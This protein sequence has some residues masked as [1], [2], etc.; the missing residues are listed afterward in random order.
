[1]QVNIECEA[2]GAD[3]EYKPGTT[4][5]SCDYCQHTMEF[6]DADAPQDIQELDLETYLNN[7]KEENDHLDLHVVSCLSCGAETALEENQQSGSCPFCDAALVITQAHSKR[8]IKPKSLLPFYI[9]KVEAKSQFRKWLTGL[10]FAPGDLKKFVSQHDKF[11]GIYLPY[12]TYDCST[13]NSYT[14]KRGDYY[15]ETETRTNA[16]GETV[17]E[18]V[19][20]TRWRTV[21]DHI[22]VD[23]DDILIPATNSLPLDKLYKLEPWDLEDLVDFKDE[24][25]S[26][27]KTESYQVELGQGY[28]EAKEIMEER[29]EQFVTEDIGGDRQ[30]II[31]I[32]TSYSQ[33]T[34]KH[35]LLPVWVSAYHYKGKLYQILVNARTGEVQG[36][37]PYSWKKIVLTIVCSLALLTGAVQLLR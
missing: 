10:W 35:L 13:S 28:D 9:E 37:R 22:Y 33:A 34:F 14:G 32:N 8:L 36:E 12:W 16:K 4:G 5:L 31:S 27:Y 15:Y 11:H 1:M 19:R 20:K 3:L 17:S 26:G 6:H 23:F 24:Y 7:F 29:I 18:K 30:R 21:S 2:C 25:L